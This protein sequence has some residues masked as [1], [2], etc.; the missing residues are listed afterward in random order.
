MTLFERESLIAD[1][2]EACKPN[3]LRIDDEHREVRERGMEA[4]RKL[5]YAFPDD[6]VETENARIAREIQRFR[7]QSTIY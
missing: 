4:A 1:C 5:G 7:R 3:V 2:R 6:V